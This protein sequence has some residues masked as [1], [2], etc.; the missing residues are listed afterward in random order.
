MF[1]NRFHHTRRSGY[2]D[3]PHSFQVKY[4]GLQWINDKRQMDNTHRTCVRENFNQTLAA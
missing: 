2:V 3:L 1:R 4:A